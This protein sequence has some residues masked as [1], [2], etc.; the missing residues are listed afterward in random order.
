MSLLKVQ[1]QISRSLCTDGET[2][3]EVSFVPSCQGEAS[4]TLVLFML[5]RN[6]CH[7]INSLFLEALLLL[8]L[9]RLG[10]QEMLYR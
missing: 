9:E 2:C 10:C 5:E 8:A 7:F 4:S 1:G 6:G 3:N